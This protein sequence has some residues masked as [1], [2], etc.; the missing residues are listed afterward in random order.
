MNSF[1]WRLISDESAWVNRSSD[2]LDDKHLLQLKGIFL[3]YDDDRDGYLTPPQLIEALTSLGFNTREK[4]MKK[5]SPMGGDSLYA[6]SFKTDFKTFSKVVGKEI[7]LLQR[8]DDDLSFLFSFMDTSG[9]GYL[10]RRDLRHLLSEVP[11]SPLNSTEFTKFLRSLRFASD[12]DRINITDL[13]KQIL[14]HC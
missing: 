3:H 8:L 6:S 1:A 13:K 14:F 2:N 7:K 4:L 9:S 11:A 12:S 5:F 10:S